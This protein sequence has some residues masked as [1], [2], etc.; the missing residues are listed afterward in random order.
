MWWTN[1]YILMKL[2]VSNA[3]GANA[4]MIIDEG[5]ALI[6]NGVHDYR[7]HAAI[8]ERLYQTKLTAA[9][10]DVK[11]EAYKLFPQKKEFFD[12]LFLRLEKKKAA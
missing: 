3:A 4:G 8:I 12:N 5:R 11:D 9:L 10:S 1:D 7:L 6:K 2:L